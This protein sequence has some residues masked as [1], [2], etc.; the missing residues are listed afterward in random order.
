MKSLARELQ[1]IKN[2][3]FAM[4]RR[5]ALSAPPSPSLNPHLPTRGDRLLG[6]FLLTYALRAPKWL[7]LACLS[8]HLSALLLATPRGA[9]APPLLAFLPLS[10]TQLYLRAVLRLAGASP[11]AQGRPSS[12]S[13]PPPPSPPPTSQ[14]LPRP[15]T[16]SQLLP[17]P[18]QLPLL[19]L[20]QQLP[21]PQL[22]PL[23]TTPPPLLTPRAPPLSRRLP[24]HPRVRSHP[25]RQRGRPRHR[26]IRVPPRLA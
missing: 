8:P 1:D 9:S 7:L 6:R 24:C 10:P 3:Y 11:L 2:R 22:P 17:Q 14:P 5:D 18:R 12:L 15:L 23:P 4:R 21:P 26:R 13:H 19:L 20:P 25:R 16:P